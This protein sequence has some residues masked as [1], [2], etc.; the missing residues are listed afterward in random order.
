MVVCVPS[1]DKFLSDVAYHFSPHHAHNLQPKIDVI[2]TDL[3]LLHITQSEDKF[4]SYY[5]GGYLG[6]ELI[7]YLTICPFNVDPNNP[8]PFEFVGYTIVE[9]PHRGNG[10]T[11]AL[12]EWWVKRYRRPLL[13][14][15]GQTDEGRSVWTSMIT[16]DPALD[17]ELWE[18]DENKFHPISVVDG[19]ITPDPWDGSPNRLLAKFK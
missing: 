16:R 8:L 4:G 13:S 12:I 14:D 15:E 1:Q 9:P 17:F 19:V 2:S 5:V 3:G 6:G 18:R 11:R 10:L 7:A